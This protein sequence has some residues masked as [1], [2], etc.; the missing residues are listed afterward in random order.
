MHPGGATVSEHHSVEALLRPRA[1]ALVG[2]SAA[3]AAGWSKAI[4]ENIRAAAPDV[5]LYPI[6]PRRDVVWGERCYSSFAE[7]PG[8]VDLALVIT[9]AA[10]IPATL[11]EGVAHGL[12]AA[13]IYAAGFGEGGDAEGAARAAELAPL[14]A[15]GL[16][17]C[18]PNCMG[19]L[20]VAERLY[21]YPAARVRDVLPG[22]VGLV[23]QSG[24]LFQYWVQ[25]AAARGLGLSYAIS[26]GNELDLDL[27]D[28]VNFLVAD[29]STKLICILAEGIHRPRAFMAA[30]AKA[31]A[32]RKPILMMKIGRSEG[33]K[34]AALSHTGSLAGDDRVFDAV[35]ERFGIVRVPSLDDMLES[36][37]AF[38]SGRL[39]AGSGAVF[40]GYSG[41]ARGM[42]LDAAEEA[43]LELVQLTPQTQAALAPL[44]DA[45]TTAENPIDLGPMAS[46]DHERYSRICQ[47]VA[48]DPNVALLAVQAQLPLDGERPDP[49]WLGATMASTAK[50]VFGYA[51][52]QQNVLET[53]RTFARAT[54]MSFLQGIPRAVRAAQQLVTYARRLGQ[55]APA[56]FV[57]RAAHGAGDPVGAAGIAR[58]G[59]ALVAT[60]EDAVACAER[61]G[62]PVALKLHSPL[63]IHKTEA[64]GVLLGLRDRDA[65]DAAARALF[66]TIAA[67]A[68]LGCDGVLVQE[69]VE[70]LELIVGMRADPQ[71]GPIV[72]L[73]LGGIF[74]EAF[75]DLA[76]RLLPV[77]S[78]AVRAMLA[79]LRG[80]RLFDAFRGRAA[81]D[82]DAVVAAVVALG[83]AFLA[84][85][86]ALEDLE[87]NP[88]TVLERGRG[89]RAVDVRAVF[90]PAG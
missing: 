59:N 2:A 90:G 34:S 38:R 22:E 15:A 78:D 57:E 87:I 50:P 86:E 83:D 18:G 10:A 25:Y 20:S 43:G 58:P 82:V 67:A 81:R 16:R 62:F 63:P 35:C 44:L 71:F 73:G 69:M 61:I 88:L 36:A 29:G 54:G 40:A 66:S 74:V 17:I 3:A 13:T 23:M 79:E 39:P 56:G 51:R 77:D 9:P 84:A 30:A 68:E 1:I 80:K 60:P 14:I 47:L 76:V 33:A 21:L 75:D 27:S 26:S 55:P 85:G 31:L 24:G 65:V 19:T 8:P 42:V 32:A 41:S 11:R 70:G 7:L 12:K 5:A 64:G 28:Y 48:A 6:N 49:Q 53:S 45:G 89:V 37:L 4:F 52:T 46:R 72:L